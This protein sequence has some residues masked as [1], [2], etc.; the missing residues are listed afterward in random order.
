[1]LGATAADNGPAAAQ[2]ATADDRRSSGNSG[3]T[4]AREDGITSA[5][6]TACAT[7]AAMS[8]STVGAAADA[9]AEAMKPIR[10]RLKTRR[11]PRRSA[12]RPPTGRNAADAM[13]NPEATSETV[14]SLADENSSAM[15]LNAR[16]VAVELK[17]NST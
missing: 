5:P 7:R 16:L 9:I 1:M 10:P 8:S 3:K 15:E 11:R 17:P 4:T 12:R 2:V 6:A 14:D 13:K